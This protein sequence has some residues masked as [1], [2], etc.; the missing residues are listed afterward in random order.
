MLRHKELAVQR[1]VDLAATSNPSASKGKRGL[2]NRIE[3]L[4]KG[5]EKVEIDQNAAEEM[6]VR[7][8]LDPRCL[9]TKRWFEN[10]FCLDEVRP[11]LRDP[12]V[13]MVWAA[14]CG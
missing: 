4:K 8:Y 10:R 6:D 7:V 3:L 2:K 5:K 14:R 11:C 12:H 1:T 9:S 13:L